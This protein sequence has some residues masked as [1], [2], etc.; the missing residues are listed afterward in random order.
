M[1]SPMRPALPDVARVRTNETCNQNCAFCDRRSPRED[2]AFVRD[3]AARIDA[4]DAETLILTGGEPTLRRDLA[5]LIAR[6]DARTVV[7]ETN[8]A[9]VDEARARQLAEAGLDVARVHLPAWG[10]ALDAI[11]RDPG[12]FE[13]TVRG[14]RALHAAGV[15]VEASAPIVRANAALLPSLPEQLTALPVQA[16]HVLAPTRAPDPSTL[17]PLPEAARVL[18]RVADAA[19]RVEL[20]LS[21]DPHASVPPCLLERPARHAH[22]YSLTPGGRTRPGHRQL[23]ACDGCRVSDRCPGVPEHLA[24]SLE[25]ALRP[26]DG[27][28]VRRRLSLISTPEAQVARELYQDEILRP[29]GQAA[30]PV[31]TV[32]IGFRCNQA[33]AFCF[34]STHLPSAPRADVERAILEAAR[35]G[36]A[37]AISGGEP[38]LDPALPEYVRLAKDAG[39]DFVEIQSNATRVDDALAASLRS[40]GADVIHVSLHAADGALSDAIT[41]APGTFDQTVRGLDALHAAG[42]RLRLSYVF[43]RRNLAAFTDLIELAASRWPG[44][45]VAVSFVAPSTDLVPRTEALIPRYREVMPHLAAGIRIARERGVALSGFESLCGVP[46]CLAPPDL[47]DVFAVAEVDDGY[48][49]GETLHPA[50]CDDCA[51]RARCFGVRRG[52]VELYG[53]DELSP[54][55]R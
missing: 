52:Y 13:A 28:R 18:E 39:A 11:T 7:L 21:L 17:L 44:T 36:A 41:D 53:T 1:S 29:A 6:A 34:V 5:A 40:A 43:H 19:R 2:R 9:L 45:S 4:A 47:L 27:D 54:L 26:I 20:P 33:C 30:R 46:L 49:D 31:R 50:P 51:L 10:D 15:R 23:E 38:T 12:G 8:A 55:P 32:R 3:A 42:L 16:L 22:L 14:V 48:T 37:I 25:G 35:E 24:A